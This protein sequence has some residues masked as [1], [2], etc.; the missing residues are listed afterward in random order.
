MCETDEIVSYLDR[1][2]AY[3]TATQE[4]RSAWRGMFIHLLLTSSDFDAD[5]RAR[6]KMNV[7]LGNKRSELRGN[8]REP[9][10]DWH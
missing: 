3:N 6:S 5:V 10:S 7:W 2:A 8:A 1:R 9:I 4:E